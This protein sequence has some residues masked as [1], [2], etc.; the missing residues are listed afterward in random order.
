LQNISQACKVHGGSRQL[1][2]DTKKIYEEQG[3]EGLR[4]KSRMKP[5]L[6]NRIAPEIEEAGGGK[7][8]LLDMLPK[9]E[10]TGG[11]TG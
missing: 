2:Y 6:K 5:C 11:T 7:I 8:Q 9:E 10:R 1:F 3:L 4:E